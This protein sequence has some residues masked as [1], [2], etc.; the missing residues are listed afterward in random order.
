MPLPHVARPLHALRSRHPPARVLSSP[1]VRRPPRFCCS[2]RLML[3][4]AL[5]AFWHEAPLTVPASPHVTASTPPG[6]YGCPCQSPS[7]SGQL[8]TRSIGHSALSFRCVATL[9]SLCIPPHRSAVTPCILP[10]SDSLDPPSRPPRQVRKQY[11]FVVFRHVL[12]GLRPFNLTPAPHC[13]IQ[14]YVRRPTSQLLSWAPPVS[15]PRQPSPCRF[16]NGPG[17]LPP[18]GSPPRRY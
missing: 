4:G 18:R 2:A 7:C 10:L 12:Q 6:F 1:W 15:S 14:L 8:L 16:P 17:P 11:A 9:L 5:L 13:V 3:Y